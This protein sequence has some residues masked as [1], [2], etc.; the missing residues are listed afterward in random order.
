[1]C[2][3]HSAGIDADPRA[4]IHVGRRLTPVTAD[5]HMPDSPDYERLFAVADRAVGGRYRRYR[6]MTPR[7]IPVISLV[8]G[9]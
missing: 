1:M 7:P 2:D 4:E 9:R 5:I 8:P 3:A 6:T